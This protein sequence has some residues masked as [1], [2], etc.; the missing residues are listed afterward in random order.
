MATRG[1]PRIHQVEP[2]DKVLSRVWLP[3]EEGHALE[4]LA[5]RMRCSKSDIVRTGVKVML[6]R[7]RHLKLLPPTPVPQ[8]AAARADRLRKRPR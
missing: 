5:T 1:R 8:L 4:E 2:D 3:P 7:A 6:A